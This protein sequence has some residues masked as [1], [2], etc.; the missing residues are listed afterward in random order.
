MRAATVAVHVVCFMYRLKGIHT[1]QTPSWGGSPEMLGATEE[2]A[3]EGWQK[4]WGVCSWK[5]GAKHMQESLQAP[6]TL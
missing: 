6:G 3:T 1:C 4:G 2:M 5:H